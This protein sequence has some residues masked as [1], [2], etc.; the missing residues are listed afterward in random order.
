MYVEGTWWIVIK[1]GERRYC[2]HREILVHCADCIIVQYVSDQCVT[3]WQLKFKCIHWSFLYNFMLQSIHWRNASTDPLGSGCGSPGICGIQFGN[4]WKYPL[5]KYVDRSPWKWLWIPWDQWNKLWEP[6]KVSTG[7][8]CRQ[9]PLDVVVDPLGSVEYTLGTIESIRW[10][11]V[12]T[13]PLGS[14]CGSPEI[15]GIHFGNHWNYPLEKCVERSPWKCLWIPWDLWNTLWELLKLSTGEMCRQT[16]LDV[17]VDPLGSVE[18]TLGTTES[19]HWRN[20]LTDPL[21]S[22][23]GSP[24]ICGIHFG[25]HWKYPLEKCVDRSPWNWLWIPWDPWNGNH[26]KYALEKCV[27]R[28]PWMLFWI[29]WDQWNYTLGTTETIHWRN[30]STDPLGSVECTLG[31]TG[32]DHYK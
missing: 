6:L 1:I 20:V 31:T 32:L 24:G 17:V 21:G 30:V 11:N 12:S 3:K 27:D 5:E 23:C 13:D 14:G 29:P 4:H 22:G 28:S 26:W 25:N 15:C 10:R 18:Y 2:L 16:P 7:E 8:M 19:I 9:I